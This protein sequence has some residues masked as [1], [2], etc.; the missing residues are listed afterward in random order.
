VSPRNSASAAAG[1]RTAILDRAVEVA[2]T[3]GL[4]GLTIGR[5][6]ADVR[7]SKA[8]VIG[9]FGTKE[10]LQLAAV[11][12]ALDIYRREVW[13]PAARAQPGLQ[14][15]RA[16][17]DAWI[18]YFEREVF[19]GGCFLTAASCEFDDR[20]GPVRDLVASAMGRWLKTLAREVRTAV[21]QGELPADADPAQVA[22]E[23]NAIAMGAN[24]QI[25]LFDDRGGL[26]RARRAMGRALSG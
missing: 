24:Q 15:L 16:V 12:A 25:R 10:R 14:R 4:E 5:L 6:A 13:E 9:H 26:E 22:F 17:C 2:S 3:Q 18:S 11:E 21:E 1:T 19:P 23:L 7:M 20:V 8:G